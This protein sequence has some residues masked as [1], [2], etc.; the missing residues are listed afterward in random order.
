MRPELE[1]TV[2]TCLLHI[3]EGRESFAS[4]AMTEMMSAK[5]YVFG[6]LPSPLSLT[7]SHSLSSFRQIFGYPLRR[8]RHSSI[9]PLRK[10]LIVTSLLTKKLR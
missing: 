2:G 9:A 7:Q 3:C 6:P 4:G 10:C 8:R 5:L 1:S